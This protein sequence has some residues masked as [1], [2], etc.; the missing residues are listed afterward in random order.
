[1]DG[2]PVEASIISGGTT[3]RVPLARP[4]QPGAAV[5]VQQ[6]FSVAIPR[7]LAGSPGLFGYFNGILTLDCFYPV[8][9]VHDDSGWHIGPAPDGGDHTFLDTSFYLVRVKAPASMTL[10]TSGVETARSVDGADQVVTFAAGPARDFFL[11]GSD[12]YAKMSAT[13]GETTI[14]SYYLPG[15][16]GGADTALKTAVEALETFNRRLG[17]YPYTEL[18]IVPLPLQGG[19]IGIE[20]P[21][22]FGVAASVYPLELTLKTTV[23]HEAA[24]Q[25]FYN[26]VG[27]DQINQPWLD[28]AVSQYFTGLF[29]L[30]TEGP[31]GWN[32]SLTEWRN[33]WNRAGSAPIPIGLA[34]GDYTLNRYGPIVYGRGPL[35]LNA[36]AAEIGQA[37]LDECF[38]GYYQANIW[39]ITTTAS[40]QA[41]FEACSGR[42]LDAIFSGWVMP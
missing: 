26:A 33:F 13:S 24:H 21:G 27:N 9:P 34:V 19:G 7:S 20:Y 10:A 4:L 25:W 41:W 2:R 1:M 28:E 11:A 38:R 30:D 40:F 31:A 18:D 3:L 32:R 29:F 42:D 17:E 35:F 5:T 36:L 14:N 15:L 6:D 39:G 16:E 22:I 8:I 12:K 37:V 23:A